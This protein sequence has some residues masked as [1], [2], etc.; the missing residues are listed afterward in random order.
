MIQDIR[1]GIRQLARHPAFTAIAILTLAIGIG[2][3]ASLWSL[4]VTVAVRKAF[5]SAL[6]PARRAASV[7]PVEALRWD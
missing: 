1:Y 6:I 3:K 4:P 5:C 2:A 7:D